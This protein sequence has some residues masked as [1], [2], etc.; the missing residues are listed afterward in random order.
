M[1]RFREVSQ[2]VISHQWYQEQTHRKSYCLKIHIS[3]QQT[4]QL[5]PSKTW[6]SSAGKELSS[7]LSVCLF[8]IMPSQLFVCVSHLVSGAEC[9]IRLYRFLIIVFSPTL[10]NH[11]S[12]LGPQ[13]QNL[14]TK[15]LRWSHWRGF[16][17]IERRTFWGFLD[18]PK[19][20]LGPPATIEGCKNVDQ[21]YSPPA[22]VGQLLECYSVVSRHSLRSFD[23]QFLGCLNNK[24]L[25]LYSR[26][27]YVYVNNCL[28]KCLS[29]H[30]YVIS[31]VTSVL[32]C[33]ETNLHNTSDKGAVYIIYVCSYVSSFGFA[34]WIWYFENW[35]MNIKTFFL[36]N[37]YIVLK[38]LISDFYLT[39]MQLVLCSVAAVKRLPIHQP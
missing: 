38:D 7:W 39:S 31:C 5:S 36:M 11:T 32:F 25:F 2:L 12:Q 27:M 23:R 22:L 29:F 8:Y 14:K 13:E 37:V 6:W 24:F 16:Q 4:D 19:D 21:A 20:Y 3:K 34:R 35:H 17:T 28:C 9:G 30:S 18:L 33:S 15:Y 1:K 10:G 26:V